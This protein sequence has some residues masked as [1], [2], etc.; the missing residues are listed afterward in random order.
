MAGVAQR[1]RLAVTQWLKIL[2]RNVE[3]RWFADAF[4]S[5]EE[6]GALVPKTPRVLGTPGVCRYTYELMALTAASGSKSVVC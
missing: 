5:L 1:H 3:N 4:Q 6:L 2:D